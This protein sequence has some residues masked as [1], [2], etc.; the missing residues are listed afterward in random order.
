MALC[1]TC[2]KYHIHN[3]CDYVQTGMQPSNRAIV[4]YGRVC[5]T[6]I[7]AKSN[8]LCKWIH[9][10]STNTPATTMIGT[11]LICVIMLIY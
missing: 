7:N 2:S 1:G 3:F 10:T 4:G 5:T 8:G 9:E 6:F 11:R